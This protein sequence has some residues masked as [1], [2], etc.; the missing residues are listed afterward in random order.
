MQENEGSRSQLKPSPKP[1]L[2]PPSQS[3]KR[4]LVNSIANPNP[5]PTP[6]PQSS[7]SSDSSSDDL[8]KKTRDLPNLYDCHRCNRH[9]NF[10]NQSDRL[11]ILDSAW[12]VVLLCKECVRC[13]ELRQVCSY[14][15]MDVSGSECFKCGS[16]DRLVH[17]DCV[18]KYSVCPPWSYCPVEMRFQVCV[19]CWV[20]NSV[21]RKGKGVGSYEVLE[22]SVREAE[23]VAGRKFQVLV[24]AK[25]DAM[26]KRDV[27][28]KAV[29]F[30]SG[31]LDCV[32]E[33][34]GLE[35][36]E[37]A[38]QLHRAMNS[39][40]RI[41][42]SFG[43]VN[44][45]CLGGR[46]SRKLGFFGKMRM[47]GDKQLTEIPEGRTNSEDCE[48]GKGC[49]DIG[50]IGMG[51]EGVVRKCNP[52]VDNGTDSVLRYYQRR[53]KQRLLL[54]SVAR[55]TQGDKNIQP[56]LK[57]YQRKG[58]NKLKQMLESE[59]K[60][61]QDARNRILMHYSRRKHDRFMSKYRRMKLSSKGVSYGQRRNLY[62]SLQIHEYILALPTPVKCPTN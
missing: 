41:A 37:L 6:S 47:R 18:V 34:D 26:R 30:A 55:S 25:E 31:V 54:Q 16:C 10:A 57:C 9:V 53:N 51:K 15:L 58:R 44:Y 45:S 32:K 61:T 12:R 50:D 28:K 19:D 43:P 2:P 21:K 22:D 11:R 23:C 5:N 38:L 60:S 46:K 17:K 8:R 29:D 52:G 40:P 42:R 62:D 20:P 14:C 49:R 27:A 35:D 39:S 33:R 59:V 1:L 3:H 13:V 56:A 36:G 4:L 48:S 24:K 7:L